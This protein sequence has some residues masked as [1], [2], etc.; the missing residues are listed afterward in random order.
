M[1]L[2]LAG[3]GWGLKFYISSKFPGKTDAGLETALW[4]PKHLDFEMSGNFVNNL[5]IGERN[6]C[7]SLG[8]RDGLVLPGAIGVCVFVFYSVL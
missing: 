8:W 2:E 1:Q 3:L 7:V 4:I 5:E 6:Y